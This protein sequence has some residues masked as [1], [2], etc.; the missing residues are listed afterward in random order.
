MRPTTLRPTVWPFIP[1]RVT[2][3]PVVYF[4]TLRSAD[5][6]DCVSE[7]LV[8][9][10]RLSSVSSLSVLPSEGVGGR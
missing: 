2:Q 6:K 1:K 9:I 3:F 10:Y 7:I 8:D 5:C 4:M